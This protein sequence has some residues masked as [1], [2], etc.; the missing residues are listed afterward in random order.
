MPAAFSSVIV[1]IE[2]HFNLWL[3]FG[4]KTVDRSLDM[5]MVLKSAPFGGELRFLS[6]VAETRTAPLLCLHR[7]LALPCN[8]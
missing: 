1:N 4:A 5:A 2:R 8:R 3:K 6:S 7:Q